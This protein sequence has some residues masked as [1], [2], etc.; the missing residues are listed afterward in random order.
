VPLAPLTTMAVGGNA[1]YLV[2]VTTTDELA[3][4]L[5]FARTND[6]A[7]TVLGGGSNVL[8]PDDGFDGL[9]IHIELRGVSYAEDHAGARV[10]AKAGENWDELVA[11]CVERGL[12]GVENLS[13]IPGSVGA[14]PVQNIGAYGVE[15]A[16]VFDWLE[17]Y[18]TASDEIVT[19]AHEDC[20]FG[21]RDSIFKTDAGR[22]SIITRVGLRLSA[23][24]P[25]HTEYKDLALYFDGQNEEPT[26]EQVREA[27]RAIRGRKFPDWHKVG[28][29]GS[30]F[31]N[32]IVS[33]ETYDALTKQYPGLPGY[34]MD[35]GRIKTSAAWLLDNVC[36]LRGY[37]EGSVGLFENQPLVLVNYG[38]ASTRDI[39][40]FA[41]G[42]A[43]QVKDAT[44]IVLSREVT[45][46]S[47]K[48]RRA[49]K[50]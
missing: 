13:G 22:R 23:S 14:A 42:V 45:T 21:Y 11:S 31:Q 48:E 19:F 33:K 37:R 40:Q 1:R 50:K 9:V 46:L 36:D 24:T 26:R 16:D 41:R 32:P 44:G 5:A 47:Q 34:K 20:Q 18:D 2:R 28:T 25:V 8:I 6:C 7:W 43:K 10:T 30:F 17:A 3:E 12:G 4:A 39:E 27:V 15:L 35:D 49:Q 38:G 29:A